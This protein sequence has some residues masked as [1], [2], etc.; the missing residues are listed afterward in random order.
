MRKKR[1]LL[2]VNTYGGWTL[3]VF[4]MPTHLCLICAVFG[5]R[6]GGPLARS[7]RLLPHFI[8][9]QSPAALIK[10]RRLC[11]VYFFFFLSI[12]LTLSRWTERPAFNSF[13]EVSG[14]FFK[15]KQNFFFSFCHAGSRAVKATERKGAAEKDTKPDR[16]RR[17]RSLE[18]IWTIELVK[19]VMWPVTAVTSSVTTGA[20]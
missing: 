20:Q 1:E 18:L 11:V 6:G 16:S 7:Y 4:L 9:M 17:K 2:P 3:N 5:G 12:D 8:Y 10:L 19:Q 14:R 13:Q 15:K